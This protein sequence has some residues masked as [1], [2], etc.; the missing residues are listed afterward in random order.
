M[1]ETWKYI[2]S[3]PLALLSGLLKVENDP[4]NFGTEA[5]PTRKMEIFGKCIRILL[6]QVSI[7]VIRF[8]GF[9]VLRICWSE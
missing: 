2:L 4:K 6:E 3:T 9:G 1:L 8:V 5:M 7:L